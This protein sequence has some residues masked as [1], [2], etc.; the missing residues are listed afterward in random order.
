MTKQHPRHDKIK[1]TS[2][3]NAAG[4]K[5]PALRLIQLQNQRQAHREIGDRGNGL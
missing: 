4:L 3:A 1:T 5:T 2:K